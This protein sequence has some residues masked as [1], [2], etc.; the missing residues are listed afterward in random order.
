V[1]VPILSSIISTLHLVDLFAL[2]NPLWLAIALAVTI[3]IGSVA[4]FL[5][6]SILSRVNK[7]IVWSM[8]IILFFMQIVGNMYFSYEWVTNQMAMK[9]TWIDSFKQ[10]TEFFTGELELVNVKM[11]LTI[12]ISWPIPLISVFLLKSAVDYIG[13]DKV[14]EPE[15]TEAA[16]TPEVPESVD[17][18]AEGFFN[19][20]AEEREKYRT[21]L[22]E[23]EEK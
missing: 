7:T 13:T 21:K 6:L 12:L 1:S 17:T 19:M 10:M 23:T 3:E 2:G 9:A 4:S 22:Q 20:S 15:I 18:E 16:E 11:Y 14:T 5:T 8:F